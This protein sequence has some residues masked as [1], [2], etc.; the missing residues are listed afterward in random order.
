MPRDRKPNK[1]WP[2]PHDFFQKRKSLLYYN[3]GLYTLVFG[4]CYLTIPLYK[5]FCESVGLDGDLEQKDYSITEDSD[6]KINVFRKFK[7]IFE[8]DADP[9]VNWEFEPIQNEVT[10]NAGETALAFYRVRNNED[11]PVIGIYIYL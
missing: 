11:F 9:D 4:L 1:P 8:G 5:I 2:K 6:K 10:V 3:I 7:V